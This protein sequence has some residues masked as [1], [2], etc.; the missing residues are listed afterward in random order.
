MRV[1]LHRRIRDMAFACSIPAQFA[2]WRQANLARLGCLSILSFVVIICR[3]TTHVIL[4]GRKG[5]RL[6]HEQSGQ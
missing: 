4:P 6:F 3:L 1:R 5:E 2:G